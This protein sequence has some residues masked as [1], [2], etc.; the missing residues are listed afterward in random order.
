MSTGKTILMLRDRDDSETDNIT[1]EV[2]S[3]A[4]PGTGLDFDELRFFVNGRRVRA[5]DYDRVL[6]TLQIRKLDEVVAEL[7][8]VARS[9]PEDIRDRS[10]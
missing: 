3:T 4:A 9:M 7:D 2:Q 1:L 6:A 5:E 8:H 10:R